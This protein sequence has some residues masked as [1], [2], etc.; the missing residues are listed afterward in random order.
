MYPLWDYSNMFCNFM[1]QIC[2]Q[3]SLAFGAVATLMTWIVYP[4]LEKLMGKLPDNVANVAFIVVVV[5]FAIVFSLYCINVV[6]PDFV[7]GADVGDMDA[8]GAETA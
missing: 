4:G 2:L 7:V 3:N 8:A 1:G 6:A 5:F